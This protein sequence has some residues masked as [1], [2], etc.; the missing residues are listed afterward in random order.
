MTTVKLLLKRLKKNNISMTYDSS[1]LA[2]NESA[3]IYLFNDI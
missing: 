2:E 1:R 3:K